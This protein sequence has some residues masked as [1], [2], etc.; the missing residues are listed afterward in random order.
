M[1][2]IG[3]SLIASREVGLSAERLSGSPQKLPRSG[4]GREVLVVSSGAVVSGI[5][6]RVTRISQ[7]LPVKQVAAA[8]GQSQLMWAYEKAFERLSLAWFKSCSPRRPRGSPTILNAR[9][10]S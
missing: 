5:K 6:T 4:P 9:T 3:S 1:V 10:T 2:K 8:V 7:S